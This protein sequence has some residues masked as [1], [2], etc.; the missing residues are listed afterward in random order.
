VDPAPPSA[1]RLVRAWQTREQDAG[2]E[3]FVEIRERFVPFI[4]ALVSH[5][6]GTGECAVLIGHGG[7]YMAMLPVVLSNISFD[8]ALQ[9]PFSLLPLR[10]LNGPFAKSVVGLRGGE[11]AVERSPRCANHCGYEPCRKKKAG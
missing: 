8:L 10:P 4:E 1:R 5:E 3:S 9:E 6:R 2:R 11:E 7:L